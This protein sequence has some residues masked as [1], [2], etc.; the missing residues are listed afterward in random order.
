[1]QKR[2]PFAMPLVLSTLHIYAVYI[3]TDKQNVH[4]TNA[5]VAKKTLTSSPNPFCRAFQVHN[6][7][8]YAANEN[9]G[10]LAYG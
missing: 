2:S 10:Q 8:A 4:K 6:T 3:T 9:I 7:S 1:M 5:H